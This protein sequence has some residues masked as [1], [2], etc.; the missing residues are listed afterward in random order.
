VESVCFNADGTRI[1]VGSND[2]TIRIW[3]GVTGEECCS[4]RG[5]TGPVVSVVFSPDGGRLASGSTDHSVKIW[6]TA[7]GKEVFSLKGPFSPNEGNFVPRN[8][9]FSPDG[10]RHMCLAGGSCIEW[11]T[12]VSREL[13]DR[14]SADQLVA[15]LFRQTPR[16]ADVLQ[17]LSTLVGM[18]PSRRQAALDA[19]QTHQETGG[20]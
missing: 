11:E 17:R 8:L 16:R 19:A 10:S 15:D 6:D 5:H 1:A 14:R 13:Q 3:N 4:L 20:R 2:S 18:S 12:K 9:T 7:S